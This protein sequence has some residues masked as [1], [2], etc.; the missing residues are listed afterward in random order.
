MGRKFLKNRDNLIYHLFIKKVQTLTP[1]TTVILTTGRIYSRV[2]RNLI[3]K[4]IIDKQPEEQAGFRAGRS[5]VDNIF[6]L[7]IALEKITQ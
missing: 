3:E 7:Q 6:T 5:T 1:K 4:E 2:L